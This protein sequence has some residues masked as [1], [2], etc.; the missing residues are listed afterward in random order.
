MLSEPGA[1]MTGPMGPWLASADGLAATA[2]PEADG[3]GVGGPLQA[4]RTAGSSQA[5]S[6]QGGR[7]QLR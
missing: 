1:A 4:T 5:D 6:S 3:E 2:G 7:S